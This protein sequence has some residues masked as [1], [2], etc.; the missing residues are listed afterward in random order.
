MERLETERLILRPWRD[1]DLAPFAAM[2]ADPRV[3]EYFPACYDRA[4]SDA[5]AAAIRQRCSRDGYGLYAVEVKGGPGFAGFIGFAPVELE[6]SFAP[7]VEIGWRL[8][9]SCWG[10]G[11]ATEGA[12]ACVDQGGRL[13]FEE[14]VSFTSAGNLRS[15]AVMERIGMTR[16][17]ADDFDHPKLPAGHALQR[18][19]LYRMRLACTG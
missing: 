11:Y 5:G 14:I 2:N 1:E 10:I 12:L 9:V 3:M 8:A 4:R 6:V 19:V 18:H 17:E 13:G 16:A 7:A 15:R